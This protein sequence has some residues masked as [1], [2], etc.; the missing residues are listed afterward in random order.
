MKIMNYYYIKILF[1]NNYIIKIIK[2]FKYFAG[3]FCIIFDSNLLLK[4]YLE[5]DSNR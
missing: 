3:N 5:K 1:I 2:G 4:Y